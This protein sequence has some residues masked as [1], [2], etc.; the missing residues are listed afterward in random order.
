MKIK[1]MNRTLINVLVDFT[2]ALLF[3]GMIATGYLLRFPLPP[4]SNKTHSLWGLTRHQWGDIHFW[5]SLGL[6][7]MLVVHLALHWSWI[8]TVIGKRYHLVTTP[9]SSLVR[10]AIWTI[11][12][13]LA[14]CITFAWIAQRSVKEIPFPMKI[15]TGCNNQNATQVQNQFSNQS[16]EDKSRHLVWMDVYPVFEKNC[17]ACH[18]SQ[19]PMGNFRVEYLEDFF[20]HAQKPALVIPSKSS[21]SP[22]IEI[23]SGARTNMAMAKSHKLSESEVLLIKNWI[24][25]GA[26]Q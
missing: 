1:T 19:K 22:L 9:P 26:K 2:V 24:D 16:D 7:L 8:V 6:V 3:L 11:G 20:N 14:I 21:Q 12:V 18:G 17:L 4:S 15:C 10:S 25:Q 23:I 13:F 5:I